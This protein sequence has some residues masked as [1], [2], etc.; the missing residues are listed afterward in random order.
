MIDGQQVVAHVPNLS[1]RCLTHDCSPDCFERYS[2]RL[3]IR[4]VVCKFLGADRQCVWSKPVQPI[5]AA[6]YPE[7]LSLA[8]CQAV[9]NIHALQPLTRCCRPSHKQK[10]AFQTTPHKL[11]QYKLC[12]V[13]TSFSL[14][15]LYLLSVPVVCLRSAHPFHVGPG[16]ANPWRPPT[17][18]EVARNVPPRQSNCNQA[19]F[20]RRNIE[21]NPQGAS[22]TKNN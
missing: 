21:S 15:R 18:Q 17:H 13:T 12:P 4:E 9:V 5:A 22:T 11:H 2:A 10:R 14:Y 3:I 6:C 1:K 19:V 8:Q 20:Q 16:H 7:N